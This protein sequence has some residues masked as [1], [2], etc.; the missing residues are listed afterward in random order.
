MSTCSIRQ[1]LPEDIPLIFQMILDLA[2]FHK[3]KDQVTNTE[4]SLEKSLFHDPKGPDAFLAEI[5]GEVVGFVLFYYNYSTFLGKKGIHIEDL[6][7]RKEFRGQG[8][9]EAIL[10]EV[11]QLAQDKG[12]GRVEW[13]V[14]DSNKGAINF[15]EKIGA[16]PL[17]NWTVYRMNEEIIHEFID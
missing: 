1:A 14:I 3:Q 8:V 4:A 13:L 9:G 11:C 17:S 16:R 6:Y 5:E 7:I 15:Y 2:D 10:K 12:Y